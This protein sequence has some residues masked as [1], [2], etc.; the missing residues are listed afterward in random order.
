MKNYLYHF[1]VFRYHN[2]LYSNQFEQNFSKPLDQAIS[3]NVHVDG[4]NFLF[5]HIYDDLCVEN[6]KLIGHSKT[7]KARTQITLKGPWGYDICSNSR[8]EYHK[9]EKGCNGLQG[10]K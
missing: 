6:V 4:T 3:A 1:M 2:Y 7:T 9:Q 8:K 5:F 10:H